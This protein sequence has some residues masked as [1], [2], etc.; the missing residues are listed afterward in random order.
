MLQNAANLC[1]MGYN[2][3]L[4]LATFSKVG[5]G[6]DMN[7]LNH[8]PMFVAHAAIISCCSTGKMLQNA[9]KSCKIKHNWPTFVP[10][11]L[12]MSVCILVWGII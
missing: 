10:N 9:A 2:F 4:Q 11:E 7:V 1:K 8:Q 3:R 12:L 5:L 6:H